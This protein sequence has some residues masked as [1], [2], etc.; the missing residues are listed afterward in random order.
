M[1]CQGGFCLVCMNK[2]KKIRRFSK[3]K[4][5][6]F[7][8]SYFLKQE[9]ICLIQWLVECPQYIQASD[10]PPY[11]TPSSAERLT[12]LTS[13]REM[14]TLLLS[15]FAHDLLFPPSESKSPWALVLTRV[16][17]LSPVCLGLHTRVRGRGW[18]CASPHRLSPLSSLLSLLSSLLTQVPVLSHSHGAHPAETWSLLAPTHSTLTLL[19]Y[20]PVA[21]QMWPDAVQGRLHSALSTCKTPGLFIW[22]LVQGRSFF[23][24][25][26]VAP[27]G[28]A[29]LSPSTKHSLD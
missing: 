10:K 21:M 25:N 13:N 26:S 27:Y 14:A 28:F 9:S 11:R 4:S 5:A 3:P 12:H 20:R 2:L 29:Q 15:V 16:S 7:D 17:H 22:P 18:W 19:L 1:S 24:T 23:H 6:F 8:Q